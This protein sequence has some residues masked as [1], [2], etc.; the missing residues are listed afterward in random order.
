MLISSAELTCSRQ[1]KRIG[2]MESDIY[3]GDD[4]IAKASGSFAIF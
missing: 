1:G 3:S 4:L 2:F